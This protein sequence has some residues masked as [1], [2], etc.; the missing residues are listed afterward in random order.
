MEP[1]SKCNLLCPQCSRVYKGGVNP[2]LPLTELSPEDY[3]SIFADGLA[4]QLKLIVFNGS[5]GDPAAA[6]NLDYAIE[7]CL[8][9]NITVK[10]ATNGSLRSPSYWREL[11]QKL[12]ASSGSAVIFAIDGLAD[13]N[14]VYRV[15]S[16][17]EKIME[18]ARAFIQAGGAARWDFIVFEHNRHQIEEAK[19]LARKMGFA[20]FQKKITSRFVQGEY[21]K[22]QEKASCPV[23]TRKG[24]PASFLRRASGTEDRL[25]KITEKYGSFAAYAETAPVACKFQK[26]KTLFID[27]EAC[28]YPCCWTGAPVYFAD[29]EDFQKKQISALIQKY[30]PGFNSLRRRSLRDILSHP[31]FAS[32]LTKSWRNKTTDEKNPK[33]MTCAR[34]C[35]PDYEFTSSP[36]SKNSEITDLKKPQ[37]PYTGLI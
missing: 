3:E 17:F 29:P 15:N 37:A 13:T 20:W 10:I 35:G 8:Q 2:V 24:K 5:Y 36:W 12:S 25:Q 9:N 16:N 7:K 28:V 23:F 6:K 22:P 31:Y 18:N 19:A 34:T 27:F 1:T 33:L 26:R 32:D 30:K 4:S 11:A 21:F 14:A